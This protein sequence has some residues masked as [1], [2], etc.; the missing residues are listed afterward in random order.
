[1]AK[2]FQN[3]G[4]LLDCSRNGVMKVEQVKFFIDCL[5][6]MGYNFL[7]LYTE[8]TFE[9]DGEPYFGYQRGRYTHEEIR[10]IDAYAKAQ[11]IELI[12][13]IQTLAHL[14]CFFKND[15][16][17]E[18]RDLNDILLV[19]EEKTYEFIEK[20][21]A[22]VAQDF[23]SRRIN[24]GMDEA[25]MVGLGRYLEKNGHR[26]R[27]EILTEH[28]GRVMKI[29][30]KYGF[31]PH[32]WSDMFFRL[33]NQGNYTSEEKVEIP[34]R[35]ISAVP[36]GVELVYW[37]YYQTEKRIYDNMFA[38]HKAFENE[39]WFAGGAWCW[40]DF[41]P[42][43]TVTMKTM[44]PAILSAEEHGV[45]NVIIT[46]W[47]DNGR[48]CSPFATLPC[49][50]ELK[51]YADGVEDTAEIERGFFDA[52]G[53]PFADFVA[54]EYPNQI[55]PGEFIEERKFWDACK[56]LLYCDPFMGLFDKEL[57]KLPE[58]PYRRYAKILDEAQKRAGRFAYLFE[59]T[60]RL[61]DVLE[62]KARLGIRTRKAYKNKDKK[63]LK[64]LVKE[65][66]EL[67]RRLK[68]FHGAFSVLWHTDNKPQ[69]ME[70]Q[71]MRIGGLTA[72]VESCKKRLQEYLAGKIGKIDELEE[73]ILPHF[74]GVAEHNHLL[75]VTRNVV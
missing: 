14:P 10:E 60:K 16:T 24:I 47:G 22:T 41:V 34:E 44:K 66:K 17:G 7:E 49:L 13:C 31:T 68:A 19:G 15:W 62:S 39:L 52:F 53:V 38:S 70:V 40:Y 61:C 37:D 51:A 69:G 46:L 48:D 55:N 8:D 25:H 4:V 26:D 45:K 1:M 43:Y 36:K 6:K 59:S 23:S 12:P 54:L 58:T 74:N 27:F 11:G 18:I 28:L 20:L 2:T 67:G 33:A 75:T 35:V 63:A 50:Y 72:R 65:Y 5:K 73:E 30:E 42:F 57:E 29:A 21:F 3:F 32:M 71:D 9:V 56:A 64:A